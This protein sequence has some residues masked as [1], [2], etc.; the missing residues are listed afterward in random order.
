M[1]EIRIGEALQPGSAR[2]AGL[3]ADGSATFISKVQAFLEETS[4]AL[5]DLFDKQ[6]AN[7]L[8]ILL[9]PVSMIAL[10]FG[11]WRVGS[12]LGWTGAF[13]ISDGFFS[14]WQVWLALAGA[15]RLAASRLQLRVHAPAKTFSEN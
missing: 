1:S 5:G 14:H 4:A 15:L 3:I 13:V 6:L 12:D 11:L 8:I 9:T 10:V 2:I 7:V